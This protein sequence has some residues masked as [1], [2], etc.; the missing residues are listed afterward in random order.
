MGALAWIIAP[1]AV[2]Y[3]VL[4]TYWALE[5]GVSTFLVTIIAVGPLA[6][7]AVILERVFPER[8]AYQ[9]ADQA[10]GTDAAHYLF[11]YNLG[12][13][14]ALLGCEALRRALPSE[15][16][17]LT[18]PVTWPL[19]SQ[20]ILAAVLAEGVSYW[21]HR[22]SHRVPWLWRFHALHH[23]GERLT[24]MRAGRFHFVD[25]APGV[26]LVFLPLLLLRAPESIVAWASAL[27]GAFGVIEHAN[28][29]MRT[30][31]FLN[32]I[33]C[34]PAVHRHHHSQHPGE[35]DSNF[36]TFTMLFD[37]LFGT[38]QAPRADG[39]ARVGVEGAALEGGFWRQLLSPF[40][41]AQ[42]EP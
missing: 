17:G 16:H 4:S 20:V 40:R 19:W 39:P 28:V 27:S 10:V 26:F 29:R 31:S 32:P 35:S 8:R 22:L 36:G 21:Q 18:W 5:H 1:A 9:A 7:A 6:V 41:R 34:T 11:N 24:L 33:V 2:S 37:V 13:V 3:A 42:R 30:P 12:Y 25:I 15:P 14:L 23:Q 38:Y